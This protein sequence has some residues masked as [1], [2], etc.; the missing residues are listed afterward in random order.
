MAVP[1]PVKSKDIKNII[2]RLII[3]EKILVGLKPTKRE[4]IKIITP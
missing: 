3:T 4:R 1:R 2:T